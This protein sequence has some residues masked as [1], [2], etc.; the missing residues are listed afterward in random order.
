MKKLTIILTILT[1]S[2]A[3]C[4]DEHDFGDMATDFDSSGDRQEQAIDDDPGNN[5]EPAGS[6]W[7]PCLFD[8]TYGHAELNGWGCEDGL[9][10]VS[11]GRQSN[12][13]RC[14]QQM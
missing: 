8:S 1:L 6:M 2:A 12:A 3:S 11:V 5:G 10:R 7:G 13:G 9:E 4:Q 14:R